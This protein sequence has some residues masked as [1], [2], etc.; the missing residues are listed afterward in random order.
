MRTAALV[1]RLEADEA[2]ESVHVV[3]RLVD[4]READ[5]GVAH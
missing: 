3:E 2:A 1:V 5:D 4:H